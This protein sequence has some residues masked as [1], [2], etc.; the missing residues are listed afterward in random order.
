M[1]NDL[2]I[3]ASLKFLAAFGTS[4]KDT[5]IE[6]F[7]K[8]LM[9]TMDGDDVGHYTVALTSTQQTLDFPPGLSTSGGW[10]I[11]INRGATYDIDIR[12]LSSE[13]QSV[14]IPPGGFCI[15]R[16]GSTGAHTAACPD[17][18]SAIDPGYLEYLVLEA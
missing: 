11:G 12:P 8:N 10:F 7:V 17:S 15:F 18:A 2:K 9:V 6:M 14:T 3:S 5:L 13:D 4:G 1:A 16:L